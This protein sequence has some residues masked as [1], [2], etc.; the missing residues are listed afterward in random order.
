[1]S[2]GEKR[3]VRYSLYE[4]IKQRAKDNG[5]DT[6]IESKVMLEE[7]R[8]TSKKGV[9]IGCKEYIEILENIVKDEETK[10]VINK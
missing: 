5:T 4:T 6:V 3:T 8:K 2:N 9:M 7:L 10:N 1:M